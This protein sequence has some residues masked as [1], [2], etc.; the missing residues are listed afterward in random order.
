MNIMLYI[1]IISLILLSITIIYLLLRFIPSKLKFQESGQSKRFREIL[2][3][4]KNILNIMEE[5][6]IKKQPSSAEEVKKFHEQWMVLAKLLENQVQ[7]ERT[8]KLTIQTPEGLRVITDINPQI[9]IRAESVETIESVFKDSK[10]APE[11]LKPFLNDP[12][13]RVRA[14]AA[15][16]IYPYSPKLSIDTLQ[17]MIKST[18]K[19]MRLSAAWALGEIGTSETGEMLQLLLDDPDEAV[20]NTVRQSVQK[21]LKKK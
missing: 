3:R 1:S 16:A 21:I 5:L 6:V 19:W 12:N 20:K 2:E 18:D 15:K 9:R 14:N 7:S 17:Q 10:L 4:E 8:D 13:N 11:M